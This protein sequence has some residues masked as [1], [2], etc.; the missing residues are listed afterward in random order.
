MRNVFVM[1]SVAV[2]LTAML[3]GA[4]ANAYPGEKYASEA[5]ITLEQAKAIALKTQA[6]VVTAGELEREPGGSG[7]RYSFDITTGQVTH[8]VGVD[9][10]TGA[11]LENSIEGPHAD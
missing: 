3:L 8:E 7:L 5:K 10:K 2:V 11:V 4:A 9:A 1:R 6:G